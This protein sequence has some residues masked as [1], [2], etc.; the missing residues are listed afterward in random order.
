VRLR[1]QLTQAVF[2]RHLIDDNNAVQDEQCLTLATPLM[3]NLNQIFLGFDT[4][5]KKQIAPSSPYPALKK[6][7]NEN[8]LVAHKQYDEP[9]LLM[10]NEKVIFLAKKSHH[11]SILSTGKTSQGNNRCLSGTLDNR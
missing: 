3:P 8:A 6:E 10:N 4:T 11:Q 2:R 9:I 7:I 5:S 1:G